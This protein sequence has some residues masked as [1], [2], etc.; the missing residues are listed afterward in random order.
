MSRQF[1]RRSCRVFF[2]SNFN[3][4]T[5]EARPFVISQV[6]R[7][8]WTLSRGTSIHRTGRRYATLPSEATVSLCTRDPLSG[9]RRAGGRWIDTTQFLTL[10]LEILRF[11]DPFLEIGAARFYMR[12]HSRSR[13]I[14]SPLCSAY[15][16]IALSGKN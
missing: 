16:T 3:Y 2:L 1:V 14:R 4:G 13:V 9:G 12:K 11:G 6:S 10:D 15:S 5:L 8:N 7:S